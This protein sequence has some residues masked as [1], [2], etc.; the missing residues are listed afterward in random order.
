VA[1]LSVRDTDLLNDAV[2][3]LRAEE[4]GEDMWRFFL[5]RIDSV[6]IWRRV[7]DADLIAL[8]EALPE[9]MPTQSE[10]APLW[11]GKAGEA[12]EEWR[13][14]HGHTEGKK[15]FARGPYDV[16]EIGKKPGYFV[17]SS[18]G[19]AYAEATEYLNTCVMSS[20]GRCAD[21]G[22]GWPLQWTTMV[23]L[24]KRT[25]RESN[26]DIQLRGWLITRDSLEHGTKH[27]AKGTYGPRR[28]SKESLKALKKNTDVCERFRM[29]DDD[30]EVYYYGRIIGGSGFEPLY[31]FGEPNAGCTEIQYIGS[32]GK[33]G[34][35]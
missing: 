14:E 33:W 20:D 1:K 34:P 10:F 11:D 13:R 4:V 9:E 35:L 16:V 17:Y 15:D 2:E 12:Y 3:Y 24:K 29:L 25:E 23:K 6:D 5:D 18:L 28:I 8:G 30:G 7:D 27:D 26:P 22:D 19:D 32:N 31:D 21:P